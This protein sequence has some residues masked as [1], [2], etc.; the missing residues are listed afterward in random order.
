MYLYLGN[1]PRTL[2]L[3]TSSHDERLGRPGRALVFRVGEGQSKAIVEFLHKDQVDL[4]SLVKLTTR[5]VKGCLGLISVDNG[6]S[7]PS[8]T[9]QVWSYS[10]FVSRCHYQCHRGR[11]HKTITIKFTSR[12]CRSYSWSLLLQSYYIYLGRYFRLGRTYFW[13]WCSRFK[14]QRKLQPAKWPSVWA[15]VYAPHEDSFIGVVLLCS[16][17]KMGSLFKTGTAPRKRK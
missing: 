6:L 11:K 15:S 16:R 14:L 10:R 17:F 8:S 9:I 4:Q 3:V 1:N 2:Y 12:I 13:S 5:V 7:F